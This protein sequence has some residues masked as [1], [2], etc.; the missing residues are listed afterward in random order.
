MYFSSKAISK[1]DLINS[2]KQTIEINKSSINY[3]KGDEIKIKIL[4]ASIEKLKRYI[5]ELK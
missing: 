2:Y 4:N 5:K 3:W 1:K